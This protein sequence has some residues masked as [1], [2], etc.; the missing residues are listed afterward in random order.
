MVVNVYVD[1]VGDL[2]IVFDNLLMINKMIVD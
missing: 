1:V 2:N